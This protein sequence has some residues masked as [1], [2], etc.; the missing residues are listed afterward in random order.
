MTWIFSQT[1]RNVK[2]TFTVMSSN[3]LS[4]FQ[5]SQG[6]I[7]AHYKNAV[8][9]NAVVFYKPKNCLAPFVLSSLSLQGW[10]TKLAQ[11]VAEQSLDCQTRLMT[12][13]SKSEASSLPFAAVLLLSAFGTKQIE[14]PHCLATRLHNSKATLNLILRSVCLGKTTGKG[15]LHGA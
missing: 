6:G 12:L 3:A 10:N 13:W 2:N 15:A 7:K 14:L 1:R 4:A 11:E 9:T 8:L 5:N